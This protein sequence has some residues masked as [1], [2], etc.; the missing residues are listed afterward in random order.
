[1]GDDRKNLAEIQPGTIVG[2][3]YEVV[4]YIGEGSMGQVYCAQHTELQGHVV[5]MKVLFPEFAEDKKYTERFKNEIFASYGVFHPN[6]VRAYEYMREGE[7]VAFTMEYVEGGDLGGMLEDHPHGLAYDK[8]IN[9]MMQMCAGVQA[10]HETGIIHRDLKPENILIRKDGMVKIADFGIARVE[11]KKNLTEHGSVVG[12]LNYVSPEYLLE[13]KVDWRS[14]LYA[15]GVLGYEMLTGHLPWAEGSIYSA[16]TQRLNADPP[17]PSTYRFDIPP[18]LE[19]VVLKAMNRDI[20]Q[21]YQSAAD[22]FVDLQALNPNANAKLS[23]AY[24]QVKKLQPDVVDSPFGISD[25][26]FDQEISL[27]EEGTRELNVRDTTTSGLIL[28]RGRA[29]FIEPTELSATES[30]SGSSVSDSGIF[31]LEDSDAQSSSATR[32]GIGEPTSESATIVA[33][34]LYGS[35]ASGSGRLD[36]SNQVTQFSESTSMVERLASNLVFREKL[37]SDRTSGFIAILTVIAVL[38]ASFRALS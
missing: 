25:Y 34:N 9:I 37:I 15:I 19:K 30:F 16:M 26:A 29:D 22:I 12:T 3:H 33:P 1:V 21:R 17:V 32:I 38:W 28:D 10:I 11:T 6:V 5:A 24:M 36:S 14:D 31:S 27:P 2:G 20:N 23:S 35:P 18:E 13:N 8:I 4:S 7:L